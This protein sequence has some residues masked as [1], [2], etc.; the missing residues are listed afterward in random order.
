MKSVCFT[1]LF[2]IREEKN[3]ETKQK[4]DE[5]LSM[6]A[7]FWGRFLKVRGSIL[8]IFWGPFWVLFGSILGALWDF[9]GGLARYS[10]QA[11]KSKPFWGP[12]GAHL[13][14]KMGQVGGKMALRCPPWRQDGAKMANMRRKM[15]PRCPSWCE[16]WPT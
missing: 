2:C 16:K 7:L 15:A 3:T 13:A 11:S 14:A 5:F 6:L 4:I 10:Q 8:Q 9:F 12:L 1:M